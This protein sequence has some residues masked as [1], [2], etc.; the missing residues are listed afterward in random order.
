MSDSVPVSTT[1]LLAEIGLQ[2]MTIKVLTEQLAK[3]EQE[4]AVPSDEPPVLE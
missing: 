1:D 2:H 4:K 3:S